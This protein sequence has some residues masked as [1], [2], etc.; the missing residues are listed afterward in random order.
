MLEWTWRAFRPRSLS[1]LQQDPINDVRVFCSGIYPYVSF[2]F[3]QFHVRTPIPST[4]LPRV[5]HGFANV[6]VSDRKYMNIRRGAYLL[7]FLGLASNPWQYLSNA[8]TFLTVLSG[9]GIFR[10]SSPVFVSYSSFYVPHAL[11]TFFLVTSHVLLYLPLW[12]SSATLSCREY[13][14]LPLPQTQLHHTQ[15]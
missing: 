12:P 6:V 15:V 7:A 11:S 8:A 4:I 5:L 13:D 14:T 1:Y 9:F 10:T 2:I 3:I